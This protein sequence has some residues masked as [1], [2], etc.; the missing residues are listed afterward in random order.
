MPTNNT[1]T[2]STLQDND[3]NEEWKLLQRVRRAADD[4]QYWNKRSKS[5]SSKDA[6]GAYATQFLQLAAVE[7]GDSVF[8]M[9]CGTGNLAVT[10]A[11]QD[12]A[13]L[14]ADFSEGMLAEAQSR[15]ELQCAEAARSVEDITINFKLLS[16]DEDWTAAGMKHKSFDVAFASRS[17]ATFDM[18]EALGKLNAIARKQ[19]AIT[20]SCGCSPR[21]DT[22]LLTRLG[23]QNRQGRDFQYAWNILVNEGLQPSV[24]YIASPRKDSY[25]TREDAREDLGRMIDESQAHNDEAALKAAHEQLEIFLD[26]HLIN[27]PDEGQLDSKGNPEEA[28]MLDKPR[29]I[30]WAFI[31]WTPSDEAF[32]DLN[33]FK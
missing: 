15:L 8:D 29:Q 22:Q 3:W 1:P 12:H 32:Q 24:A 26:E 30:T 27:N 23:L 14:G 20:L 19:C 28:L 33:T 9:G 10:L 31:S 18:A 5:F 13:V 11:M 21:T 6:P 16:W 4:A 7:P 2:P 17:I 25:A